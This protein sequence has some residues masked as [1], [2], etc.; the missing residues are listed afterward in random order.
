MNATDEIEI[1]FEPKSMK[2]YIRMDQQ[3]PFWFRCKP[4]LLC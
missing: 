2:R 4:I 3:T 1:I